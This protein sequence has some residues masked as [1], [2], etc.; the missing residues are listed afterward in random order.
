MCVFEKVKK[1]TPSLDLSLYHNVDLYVRF[2]NGRISVLHWATS[3]CRWGWKITKEI[4]QWGEVHECMHLAAW[5]IY[6]AWICVLRADDEDP[7]VCCASYT[8]E[9]L[10]VVGLLAC[11]P[12]QL[13]TRTKLCSYFDCTGIRCSSSSPTPQCS[14]FVTGIPDLS[15][16]LL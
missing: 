16:Q 3:I 15:T 1:L 9:F 10:Q 7:T 12:H 6:G 4:S 14:C 5:A 2:A 13:R 8:W 11:C